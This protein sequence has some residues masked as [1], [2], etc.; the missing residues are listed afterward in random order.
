[1]YP[2]YEITREADEKIKTYLDTFGRPVLVFSAKN[3]EEN[4]IKNIE[5]RICNLSLSH[6]H[7][8]RSLTLECLSNGRLEMVAANGYSR[9][10][11][12]ITSCIESLPDT[13]SHKIYIQIEA[14]PN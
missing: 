6:D 10:M 12:E 5:V 2:N 3:L 4:H 13:V 7:G 9:N 11:I 14:F 8:F 1:V